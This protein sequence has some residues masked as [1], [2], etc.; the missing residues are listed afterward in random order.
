MNTGFCRSGPVGKTTAKPAAE[1]GPCTNTLLDVQFKRAVGVF[2][3][4]DDPDEMGHQTLGR[5][6]AHDDPMGQLDRV[7][8]GVGVIRGLRPKSRTNSSGVTLTR[9]K[10]V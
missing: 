4:R 2:V 8:L 9:Q 7:A 5:V 6:E 1:R 3:M 10:L